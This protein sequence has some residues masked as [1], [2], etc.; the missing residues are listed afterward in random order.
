MKSLV[1]LLCLSIVLSATNY[2]EFKKN[3]GYDFSYKV[4]L[5]KKEMV[6][7]SPWCAKEDENS[8]T[9]S[10]SSVREELKII[11]L[12]RTS[13]ELKQAETIVLKKQEKTKEVAKLSKKIQ[14][15][16]TPQK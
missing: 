12:M 3:M 2:Q 15:I 16:S 6:N 9:P 5:D 11:T 13:H 1:S 14:F 8:W 4:N 7:Y 10:K